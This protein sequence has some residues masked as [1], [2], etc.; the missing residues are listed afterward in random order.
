MVWGDN[1]HI[2][3]LIDNMERSLDTQAPTRGVSPAVRDPGRAQSVTSSTGVA[4][5]WIYSLF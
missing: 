2:I 5:L 1:N 4:V 3:F